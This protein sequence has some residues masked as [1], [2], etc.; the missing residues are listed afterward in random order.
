MVTR[1]RRF[2]PLAVGLCLAATPAAAQELSGRVLDH[3][4]GA[5]LTDV[6]VTLL[7]A[8]RRARA[9]TLTDTL[10]AFTLDVPRAGRWIV[11]AEV[12]GYGTTASEPVAVAPTER[13]ELEIRM[14]VEPIPVEPVVVTGRASYG[15]G[16]IRRFYDRVERGR[17]SGFGQFVTRTEVERTMPFEP[18]DLL[19]MMAGVRVTTGSRPGAGGSISMTRGCVPAIYVDGTQINRSLIGSSLDD[20]V[21]ANDIEGIEVYRGGAQH[22]PGY[23]D[24]RGCGLVLVWTRRGSPDGRPFSWTRLLI[25]A[26]LVLTVLF[27][28]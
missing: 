25:G 22:V 16:D 8:E 3:A 14:A 11:V 13:V 27:I 2:V 15:H 4:T 26:G 21:A 9:E 1:P 19:R 23:H 20:F 7:D 24:D 10:G 6:R 5:P 18:T 28:H 12:L 17:M